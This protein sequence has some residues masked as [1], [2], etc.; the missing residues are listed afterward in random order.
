M[1]QLQKQLQFRFDIDIELP[2]KRLP[3]AYVWHPVWYVQC[4]IVRNLVEQEISH[5]TAPTRRGMS[6]VM[7]TSFSYR[8]VP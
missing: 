6:G 5:F 8:L 3:K 7:V 2:H 4:R 1:A